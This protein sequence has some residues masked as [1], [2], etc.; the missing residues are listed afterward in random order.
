MRSK[1]KQIIMKAYSNLYYTAE[2]KN[3]KKENAPDIKSKSKNFKT[4]EKIYIKLFGKT[5]GYSTGSK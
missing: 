3:Q 2:Q 1:S 5:I 4:I